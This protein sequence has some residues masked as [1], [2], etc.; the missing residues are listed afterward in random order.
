M[1]IMEI[2]SKIHHKYIEK[3]WAL[4]DFIFYLKAKGC[5]ATFKE[6]TIIF[7]QWSV[8]LLEEND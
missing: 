6:H 5:T 2:T 4:K 8:L 1:S 7:L 3:Q